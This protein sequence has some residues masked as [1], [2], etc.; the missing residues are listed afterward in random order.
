[1]YRYYN[2]NP[3]GKQASDCVVRGISMITGQSWDETFL[4]ICT[5]GYLTKEMPAVNKTWGT[6]LESKGFKR[7]LL[8]D[9]CPSCYT[10][11]QFAYDHPRG[12]YLVTTGTHVVAVKD[13]D[14]YDAWD[15][16]NEIPIYYWRK[17]QINGV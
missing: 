12:T 5:V 2:P 9:T 3:L 11:E 10:I 6:Y 4:D 13:G 14:Y 16:G 8:P 1:M 7:T 17:E 15:S